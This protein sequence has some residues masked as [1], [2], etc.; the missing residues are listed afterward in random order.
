MSVR[1]DQ[2]VAHVALTRTLIARLATGR[3]ITL[4]VGT[5][6]PGPHDAY[7]GRRLCSAFPHIYD[8]V[9]YLYDCDETLVWSGTVTLR[10]A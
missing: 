6:H 4:P 10:P 5:A 3:R 1:N 2:L 7:L 9:V 8:G